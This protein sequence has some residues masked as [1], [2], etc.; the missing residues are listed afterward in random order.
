MFVLHYNVLRCCSTPV[1][2]STLSQDIMVNMELTSH[3][4]RS[5]H[6]HSTGMLSFSFSLLHAQPSP[7]PPISNIAI[8]KVRTVPSHRVVAYNR[9]IP[10]PC[11]TLLSTPGHPLW[12]HI[13]HH[14]PRRSYPPRLP[15]GPIQRCRWE[16]GESSAS[17]RS[18][19][20]WDAKGCL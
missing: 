5:S 15:F 1:P 19:I 10:R 2:I 16:V 18:G 9:A 6:Q 3:L 14:L 20:G 8:S 12:S 7:L 4:H 17:D 13:H 11:P